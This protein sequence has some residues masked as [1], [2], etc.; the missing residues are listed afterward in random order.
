[1]KI[2]QVSDIHSNHKNLT[3]HLK[4]NR[5]DLIII[6]GDIT[7]F[8][9]AE[10]GEEILNDIS[11]F[12]IPVLAI[13]GNCDPADIYGK[14][15]N[16]RALNVHGRSLVINGIGICG[17]GGSNHTPF[18][19]PL[20]FEEIQIYEGASKAMEGVSKEKI[21]ILLTHTPPHGTETDTLPS[22]GHAGS[23]SIRKVIEEYQPTLNLCGHIHESRGTDQIGK[24]ITANPGD[25]SRGYGCLIYIDDPEDPDSINLEIIKL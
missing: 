6:T 16:S 14:I 25:L 22:G 13:P 23:T 1:M 15:D 19:T 24:T 7:Q 10:L 3:E 9:P 21:S 5:A 18:N 11:T 2:L 8:G 17:F 12:D 4:H 20:E